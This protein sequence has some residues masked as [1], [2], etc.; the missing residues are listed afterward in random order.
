MLLLAAVLAVATGCGSGE[1]PPAAARPSPTVEGSTFASTA[2]VIAAMGRAGFPCEDPETGAVPG[3][4]EAQRC[5]VGGNEDAIVLRFADDEQR[6]A[7]LEG[8]DPLAS[9]V[10][11]ANWAVQ[12]VLPET[13]EKVGAAVGG[14]VRL[15]SG[16]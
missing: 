3:A 10:V 2:D 16:G 14:E 9:V 11:G 7:Y 5:I 13:A 15:G 6:A 8:K 1:N 4:A 12:T